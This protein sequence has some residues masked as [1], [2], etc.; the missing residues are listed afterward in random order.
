MTH[1]NTLM[2]LGPTLPHRCDERDHEAPTPVSV[3]PSFESLTR[4][5]AVAFLKSIIFE[6]FQAIPAISLPRVESLRI[7]RT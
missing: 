6:S 4:G 7:R 5:L 3:T 1:K 2:I